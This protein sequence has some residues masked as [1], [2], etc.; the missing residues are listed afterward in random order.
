M[1]DITVF[2][3][4]LILHMHVCLLIKIPFSML[5]A[6]CS[7]Q[8]YNLSLIAMKVNVYITIE[9][10]SPQIEKGC[11]GISRL[12]VCHIPNCHKILVGMAHDIH[13]YSTI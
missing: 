1:L 8:N 11:I 9:S 12:I 3:V 10:S 5:F 4:N 2:E 13:F 6:I 7:L